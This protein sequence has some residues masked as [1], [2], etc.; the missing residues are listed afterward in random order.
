MNKINSCSFDLDVLIP[1]NWPDNCNILCGDDSIRC[2]SNK[3]NV[4]EISA[5]RGFQQFKDTRGENVEDL[6]K[7]TTAIKTIVIISSS[8]REWSFTSMNEIISPKRNVLNSNH[9]SSL[10][11][12]NCVGPPIDMINTTNWIESWVNSGKSIS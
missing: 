2:L 8:V 7:L 6:K 9:I 10:V 11:F 4:D 1:K 3:C 5:V 12:I